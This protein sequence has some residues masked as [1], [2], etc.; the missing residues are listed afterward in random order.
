MLKWIKRFFGFFPFMTKEPCGA[1]CKIVDGRKTGIYFCIKNQ[2]HF[3]P[4][5]TYLGK[6][7]WP[8]HWRSNDK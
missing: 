2:G 7:Y 4:H 1:K 8:W 5:K 3:G 6:T